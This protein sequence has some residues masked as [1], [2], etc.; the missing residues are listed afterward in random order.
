MLSKN[1]L[2]YPTGKKLTKEELAEALRLAIIAELDAVNLYMQ[3]ARA[4]DDERYRKVFEDVAREER[5]HIGEFL[6]LL[7]AIDPEQAEEL[8]KGRKEVEELTGIRVE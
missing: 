5:T 3:L 2:D 7:K 4:I 8:E 6:A 1:P